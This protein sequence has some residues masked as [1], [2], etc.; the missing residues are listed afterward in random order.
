MEQEHMGAAAELADAAK[1]VTAVAG[2]SVVRIGR[3]GG[4]GCGVVI[5][6]GLVLTNAH[7]LRDGTTQVTFADG[8]AVQAAV[9]GTDVDGDLAVLSV[10]TAG[11]PAIAWAD[12]TPTAGD[13][14]F[15]LTQPGSGGTRISFGMISGVERAF[16]GPRGRR[17]AG[18]L[19]HTAP[20]AKGSSGSPVVDGD[21]KLVG[22]STNRLGDGFYLALPADTDLKDRVDAL[23]R[24][25]SP[26][27][28]TLGVGLAPSTVARKL[29]ASVGLPARDGLLVRVVQDGSPAGL[30]GIKAGDLI[31]G[32]AGNP[33]ASV[34]ALYDVLDV[35]ATDGTL[36]LQIVRGAEELDVRVSFAG[37]ADSAASEEGSA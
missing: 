23:G 2:P 6:D 9:S 37:E 27:R 4:R 12:A 5:G 15:A 3:H 8:R 13:V 30:A 32:A 11:A 18:S 7:N 16:R 29:R 34:D 17:V 28:V 22:L 21:G 1:Q 31:V 20:L 35:A 26:Q 19:E 24:G 14:V 36:A 25:E 33:V 10:D